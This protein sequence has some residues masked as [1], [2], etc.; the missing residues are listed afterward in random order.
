MKSITSAGF[1]LCQMFINSFILCA[2]L[3]VGSRQALLVALF[4]DSFYQ[5]TA[6][7]CCFADS[8]SF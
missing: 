1:F 5:G 8:N 3:G 7:G 4:L 6:L 2:T